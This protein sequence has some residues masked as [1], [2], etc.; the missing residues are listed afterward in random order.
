MR[1]KPAIQRTRAPGAV[2][3]IGRTTALQE[4]PERRFAA[5]PLLHRRRDPH[6]GGMRLVL[7]ALACLLALP[8]VARDG[9]GPGRFE[10]RPRF[11]HPLRFTDLAGNV[12]HPEWLVLLTPAG[13][14]AAALPETSG[15]TRSEERIDLSDL[16]LLGY[17]FDRRLA[18]GDAALQGIRLGPLLRFGDTLVLDARTSDASLTGRDV[19]LTAN[20]PGD[21]AISYRLGRLRFAPTERPPGTGVEAGAGYLVQGALVLAGEGRDPLIDD[22]RKFFEDHF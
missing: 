4:I 5:T 18:A 10:D 2:P 7:I 12:Y 6:V 13:A 14:L 21:G 3:G 20:F 11:G 1:F 9:G 19:V 15:N 16:P 17:L 22:W 8:A